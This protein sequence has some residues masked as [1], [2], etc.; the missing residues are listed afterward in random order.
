ME[1]PI[2]LSADR[3][4]RQVGNFTSPKLGSVQ[5]PLTA[6]QASVRHHP[7][8]H[9]GQTVEEW[10]RMGQFMGLA[11]SQDEGHRASKPVGDHTRFGPIPTSRAAQR[12]TLIS[13]LAV[14]PLFSAPAALW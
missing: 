5:G 9:P 11:W 7:L 12:F 13:P 14:G 1:L 6:A 4:T 8:R 3:R 2:K 10:N